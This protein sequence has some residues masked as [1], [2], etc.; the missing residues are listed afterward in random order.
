MRVC[1]I[2]SS[3]YPICEP[4]A[5]GLEAQ[6]ALLA[7]GFRERGHEVSLFAAAG[8]DAALGHRLPVAEFTPSGAAQRDVAA[9]PMAWM[10]EHHAYLDLML[11]LAG[12]G[13]DQ[14]DVIHNNSLHHLPIAMSAIVPTPL[15]TT[16][17]TPPLPWLESA[18]LLAASSATYAAVSAHTARAWHHVAPSRVILNGVDT[19]HWRAGP[20]GP[21]AVW[22]GRIVPEKAPHL[23]VRAARAAGLA[24][25]LAGP[26]QDQDYFDR[27]LRP[28]LGADATYLGHLGGDDLVGLIGG[29]CVAL[30]SPVWD[31]PFGLVA[32]EAMACG[33]PVA[34]FD[35]GGLRELAAPEAMALARPGDAPDLGRAV[36]EIGE[37]DRAAVR[38]HAEQELSAPRMIDDYE[39]L[40]ASM[41]EPR[42]VAA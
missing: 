21:R 13:R 27:V 19:G 29:A 36:R 39:R 24:L 32:A 25:D 40:Y 34:A 28:E 26:V 37:A 5:G 31:E 41:L 16:L 15:V 17:H 23:A 2:A 1:L 33:T 6:T 4:Y 22:T 9:M 11:W 12:E 42:D 3:A 7:R 20:G 14:F 38:R 10:R 18:A 30:V 35:R 8:S